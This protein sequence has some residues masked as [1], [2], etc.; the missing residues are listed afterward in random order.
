MY[1]IE[2]CHNKL[3]IFSLEHHD[4]FLTNYCS[5]SSYRSPVTQQLTQMIPISAELSFTFHVDLWK[6]KPINTLSLFQDKVLIHN[7]FQSLLIIYSYDGQ[8]LSNVTVVNGSRGIF[9]AK[10]SPRGNIMY[11]GVDAEVMLISD[12]G[13]VIAKY[14]RFKR[15]L[16]FSTWLDKVYLADQDEGIF[17]SS[18]EGVSWNFVFR[19]KAWYSY[20]VIKVTVDQHDD[21][22]TLERNSEKFSEGHRFRVYSVDRSCSGPNLNVTWKDIKFPTSSNKRIQ[23]N[24]LE[25]SQL[26][27]NYKSNIFFSD[28]DNEAVHSL[29]VNGQ[30]HNQLLTSEDIMNEP[31]T[32]AIDEKRQLLFVGQDKGVV[33]VFKLNYGEKNN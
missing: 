20:F 5:A 18:D 17:M 29:S 22:W 21:F 23:I 27:Y 13:N 14:E 15:P 7:N 16:D 4:L 30:Y 9:R 1:V 25:K 8:F 12:L 26:A 33:D 24:R 10:W 11:I 28:Y 3:S 6:N 32:L 2:Y 31:T 19:L